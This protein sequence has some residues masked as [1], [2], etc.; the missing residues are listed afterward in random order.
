MGAKI[1]DFI[2]THKAELVYF[3]VGL[4]V[5]GILFGLPGR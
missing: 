4:I 3:F 5:G 2:S 1:L